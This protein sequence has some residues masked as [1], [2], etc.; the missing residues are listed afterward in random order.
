MQMY[1]DCINCRRCISICRRFLSLGLE[2]RTFDFSL[3]AYRIEPCVANFLFN[4][5]ICGIDSRG[6]SLPNAFSGKI[7]LVEVDE[8]ERVREKLHELTRGLCIYLCLNDCEDHIDVAFLL[9]YHFH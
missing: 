9:S 7:G 4:Y 2:L 1:Q 5:L 6:Y 8:V 3:C